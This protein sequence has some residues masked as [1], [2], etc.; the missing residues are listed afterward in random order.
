MKTL[1][2]KQCAQTLPSFQ[3]YLWLYVEKE[4]LQC[5]NLDHPVFNNH[6]HPH[7][8]IYTFLQLW[9]HLYVPCVKESENL[10]HLKVHRQIID[11]YKPV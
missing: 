1:R 5:S 8:H 7:T 2:V 3:N 6:I 11:E 10:E 4:L 9:L